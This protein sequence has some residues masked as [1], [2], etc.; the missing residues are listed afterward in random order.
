MVDIKRKRPLVTLAVVAGALVS[1]LAHHSTQHR[2]TRHAVR[3]GC[4]KAD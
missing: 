2:S 3:C 4:R 1:C